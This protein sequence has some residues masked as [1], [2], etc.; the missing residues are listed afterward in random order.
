MK[1]KARGSTSNRAAAIKS[2]RHSVS[3]RTI[4]LDPV[5]TARHDARESVKKFEKDFREIGKALRK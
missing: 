4:T 3:R 1:A 2:T 5:E